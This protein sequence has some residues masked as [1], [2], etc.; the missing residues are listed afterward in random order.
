MLVYVAIVTITGILVVGVLVSLSKSYVQLKVTESIN[1]SATSALNRMIL[2]IRQAYDV[3]VATSTFNIHPGR[4]TLNTTNVM[5][6]NTEVTFFVSNGQIRI[7]E[8]GVDAGVLTRS[9]VQVTSLI[10]EHVTN[11]VS[12]AIRVFLV[13]EGSLGS[14]NKEEIFRTAAVLRDSYGP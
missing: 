10:F 8:N 11:N 7:L 14:V 9:D 2:E 5:G 4:L 1:E 3:D 6:S 13:I 12:E